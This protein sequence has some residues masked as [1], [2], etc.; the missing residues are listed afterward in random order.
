MK[1]DDI[2]DI[3]SQINFDDRGLVPAVVQS[4]GDGAVLMLAYMN[5]A[6]LRQTLE[7]RLMTYWSRSRAEVWVKGKTSGHFQYVRAVSVDCDGDTLLFSVD[8]QGAACH[9]GAPSCFFRSWN[10]GESE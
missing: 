9:T 5:E 1:T 4:A 6:T 8:Q 2:Q 7:T 3:V 10:V